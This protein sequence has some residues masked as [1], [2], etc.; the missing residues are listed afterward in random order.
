MDAMI[1]VRD[2]RKTYRM[3]EIDVPALRGLSFTIQRGE[4]VAIMGPSGSGKS[5]LMNL[6]GCLDTPSG[7]R[8]I[9]DGL[10][11]DQLD[12]N[13]LAAVRNRKIGFVFQQFNL[14]AR[15]TALE[16]VALPLV[17]LGGVPGE[18][19]Y[20]RAQQ[21]LEL[22]GMG[23]RLHHRPQELSGGQQQRVAIAR[24]L[25]TQPALLLADEPTGNLDS[26]TSTDILALFEE[27][28]AQGIT[29]VLVTHDADIAAHAARVLAVHDGLLDSDTS[30]PRRS[31]NGGAAA[32]GHDHPGDA[33]SNDGRRLDRSGGEHEH[34]DTN[35]AG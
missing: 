31:V 11:V 20:A 18:E 29:I 8:Y 6:L 33:R 26:R 25:I 24:A 23:D 35:G 30:T 2:L 21:M 17:Y 19:R 3:G 27:L 10:P 5:T 4:F 32:V 12:R 7:G 34:L 13:L 28:N 15:Q 14:L 16:N 22:V 1:Q 9:L